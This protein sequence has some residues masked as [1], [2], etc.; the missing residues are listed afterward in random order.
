MGSILLGVVFLGLATRVTDTECQASHRDHQWTG[1][2]HSDIVS[3]VAAI[4]NSKEFALPLP[5]LDSARLFRIGEVT[6][7][8]WVLEASRKFETVECDGSVVE[9][10][11]WEFAIIH[12]AWSSEGIT[13][14]Q[15]HRKT[16][17]TKENKPDAFLDVSPFDSTSSCAE[18]L[19]K[20]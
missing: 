10:R 14:C 1:H 13:N 18:F 15:I 19:G 12:A 9:E 16:F 4:N 8:M 7:A 5:G 11:Q 3:A 20:Q 2:S 17:V 6:E